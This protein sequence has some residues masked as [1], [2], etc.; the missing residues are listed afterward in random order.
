MMMMIIMIK[1][2]WQKLANT[3]TH[4]LLVSFSCWSGGA[5]ITEL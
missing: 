1:V 3:R 2:Q 4:L 5:G